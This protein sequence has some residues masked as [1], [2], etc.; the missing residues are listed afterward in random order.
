MIKDKKLK[1][2]FYNI[3]GCAGCLLS[4]IFNKVLLEAEEA[5]EILSFP[6]I[7]EK[8]SEEHLDVIFLEGVV[9]SNH[10][11][12]TLKRIRQQCDVLV[13]LGACATLG[14]VPALRNFQNPEN[15]QSLQYHKALEIADMQ[16]QPVD[17][18]VHVDYYL[19]GCPPDKDE[20]RRVVHE[21]IL[22]KRPY[23]YSKPVC[24]ECRK[25]RNACLLDQGQPCLGP[26]TR[27]GCNAVCVNGGLVCWGCRGPAADANFQLMIKVLKSKGYAEEFVKQRIDT[28][29]GW[30]RKESEEARNVQEY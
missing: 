2:G 21:F 27:G 28:F 8:V 18:F 9:A 5:A 12:E 15:F 22:G 7:K 25:N 16:P 10:D 20:I 29:E 13:A 3:T 11:L 26:V 17:K 1:M 30:K 14:G 24:V 23:M 6:F 4:V 19:E